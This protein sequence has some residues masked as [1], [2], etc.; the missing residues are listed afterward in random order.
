MGSAA[1]KVIYASTF[2]TNNVATNKEGDGWVVNISA[3]YR[4]TTRAQHQIQISYS[5]YV[6][7][8][9][10]RAKPNYK[11]IAETLINKQFEFLCALLRANTCK[12]IYFD[13]AFSDEQFA[14]IRVLQS[15]SHCELINTRLAYMFEQQRHA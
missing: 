11:E 6:K 2:A 4:F 12:F 9:L 13:A 5:Q 3:G 10:L 14:Q 8:L 1:K 7:P 15:C